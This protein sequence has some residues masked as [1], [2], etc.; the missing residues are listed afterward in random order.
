MGV[1]VH[2]R[3]G[4][5]T[6]EKTSVL[7]VEDDALLRYLMEMAARRSE[8]FDP[9]VSASDGRA[10]FDWL[11]GCAPADLPE[12]I[13][14]DLSMPRMSGL[15][16]VRATRA[17]PALREIPIAIVTSSDQPHDREEALAA[18]AID[19]VRKPIS[20]DALTEIFVQIRNTARTNVSH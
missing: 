6:E 14:S 3:M 7:I 8:M 18:G 4:T 20:L 19:F 12:M 13:F 16:L 15:E 9:I 5:H 1:A 17:D 10:A 11:K 2:F